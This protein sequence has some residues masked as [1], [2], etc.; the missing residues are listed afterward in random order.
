MNVDDICDAIYEFESHSSAQ[1]V[2][3]IHPKSFHELQQRVDF[4]ITNKYDVREDRLVEE[5]DI[6]V[7]PESIEDI[8]DPFHESPPQHHIE[9]LIDDL[10]QRAGE[11]PADS[12]ISTEVLVEMCEV[13]IHLE[14][15][16]IMEMGLDVPEL[17][18]VT[19]EA[20]EYPED[21]DFDDNVDARVYDDDG[22]PMWEIAIHW[23]A[24]EK[25]QIVP[26]RMRGFGDLQENLIVDRVCEQ[27]HASIGSEIDVP[28]IGTRLEERDEDGNTVRTIDDPSE[29]TDDSHIAEEAEYEVGT[30]I[31]RLGR[32][33]LRRTQ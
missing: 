24:E 16:T 17:Q 23:D 29:V 26:V 21:A 19:D 9:Q 20:L 33:C 15:D 3:F 18:Y 14:Y 7:L 13:E 5:G 2:V 32:L 10:E 25:V 11:T 4:A 1:P 27:V 8:N 6:V 22:T 31:T 12:I 30:K 28:V